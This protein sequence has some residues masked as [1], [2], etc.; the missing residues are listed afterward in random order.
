MSWTI[1]KLNF[2]VNL[3]E[4]KDYYQ[5][6]QENYQHLCWDF[7]KVK[8]GD[9]TDEWFDRIKSHNGANLGIGWAI[10]SNLVDIN[11]PCPPYNISTLP[12]CPYRNTEMAKGLIL[13][14]QQAMPYTYR[15]SLFVQLPGGTVPRH[16]DQYDECTVHI[17][18]QWDPEAVF[19][20]G[21]DE[22]NL[23]TVTFPPTG[24]AYMVNTLISHATFNR[25]I[26]DRI[27]LVFRLSRDDLEK[28]YSVTG[29]L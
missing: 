9:I 18:L 2:T 16:I 4:L 22:N 21:E 27:G 24:E 11:I 29:Q 23:E 8:R 10:Q 1:K 17:P 20:I 25:S 19:E 3:D 14:M 26:R 13:R 15:W 7:R 5:D 12:Q 6:L 28:L